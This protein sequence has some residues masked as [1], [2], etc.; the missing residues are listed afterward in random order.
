M[1]IDR[2][3]LN[4]KLDCD[5]LLSVIKEVEMN[6]SCRLILTFPN[7]NMEAIKTYL[8]DVFPA[9]LRKFEE[10]FIYD[11]LKDEWKTNDN[12]LV[13]KQEIIDLDVFLQDKCIEQELIF[14]LL[15][16]IK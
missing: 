3:K 4:L 9:V 2:V 14:K 7:K 15:G 16:K 5:K 10:N 11:K 8:P 12:I 13:T 1:K 6:K